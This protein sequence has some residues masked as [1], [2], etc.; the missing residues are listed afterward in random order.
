MQP[1]LIFSDI[2]G[3]LITR[4]QKVS[5]YTKKVI[6][7]LQ[8]QGQDFYIATGR[9]Y[10]LGR[11]VAR[12]I[13]DDVK[14]V[15]SNG[16][17]FEYQ[18]QLNKTLLGKAS[19]QKIYEVAME[20]QLSTHF[21]TTDAAY[22]THEIPSILAKN[23]A[24]L[25][26]MGT[27]IK[28]EKLNSL[29]MLLAHQDE[30]VNG[31]TIDSGGQKKALE[32]AHQLLSETDLVSVSSSGPNNIEIIPQNI[33]KA[34]AI[35]QLQS[36]TGISKDQTIVFGD[37]K[38]DLGMMQQA[39]YSVAMA[40]ALP[41]VKKIANYSTLTNEQSGVAYYLDRFFDLKIDY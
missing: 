35:K 36:L 31:I 20:N 1:Y 26:N 33:D 10:N 2:D 11:F 32:K 39:K 13:N 18:S 37:G 27:A 30:I 6:E 15:A 22:Y 17:V 38:N 9:L 28:Y 16:A 19:L 25:T 12:Q 8:N 3:T 5:A 34:T 4:D 21:F 7:T 24:N 29:E 40:N 14:I 23:A 41:E